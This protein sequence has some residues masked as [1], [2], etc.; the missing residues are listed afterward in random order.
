[1]LISRAACKS[2]LSKSIFLT[3]TIVDQ[4]L[5]AILVFLHK[6]AVGIDALRS[7]S[8]AVNSSI[9]VIWITSLFLML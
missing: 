8:D 5:M 3:A 6:N 7:S 1:M 4:L 2:L 9:L